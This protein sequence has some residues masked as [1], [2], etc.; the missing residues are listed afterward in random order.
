MDVI[1]AFSQARPVELD[2]RR[3]PLPKK[4]L[5]TLRARCALVGF[6]LRII[7]D[8]SGRVSFV[9][10]GPFLRR[11]ASAADVVAFVEMMQRRDG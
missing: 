2:E 10:S 7:E 9:V 4:E 6:E 5:S 8:N 3:P 1:R 11:L